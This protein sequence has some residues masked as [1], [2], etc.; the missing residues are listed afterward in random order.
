MTVLYAIANEYRAAALKLADLDLDAQTV[1]DTLEGL[2]GELEQKAQNVGF[3]VRA[4]EADAIAMGQWAAAAIERKK[5][6][7]AR[8][9]GLR[10]Y[11]AECMAATGVEKI[12]GPGIKLSFRKSTAVIIDGADLIPAQFMRTPEPPPPAP[13]KAAIGAELK[14][15]RDVLGAHL[16]TRKNLQIG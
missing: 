16:E 5:A 9:E 11:L 12:E 4:I 7:E 1:A 8:A 3:M 10:R 13:D 14:A 6:A 15:G 2:A